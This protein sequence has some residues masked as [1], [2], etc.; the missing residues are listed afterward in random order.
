MNLKVESKKI[1]PECC[2]NCMEF[3]NCNGT[4][5]K[6]CDSESEQRLKEA[7]KYCWGK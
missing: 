5:A 3:D 4:T 7:A 2:T 1:L 6:E